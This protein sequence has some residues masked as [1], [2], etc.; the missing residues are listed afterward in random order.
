MESKKDKII[1]IV[2]KTVSYI[3]V[4]ALASVLTLVLYTPF[5]NLIPYTIYPSGTGT[6]TDEVEAT[7]NKLRQLL[8]L[9]DYCHVA[10]VDVEVLGDAAAWAMVEATGDRW[11]AYISASE[12]DA[13][14]ENQ[15]NAY[16]GIGITILSN[17]SEEGFLIQQ[18]EPNGSAKAAGIL[19]GDILVEAEGQSL[20]GKE[21]E[22]ASSL[23]RGEEGTDV[24]VAVLRDGEKITFTL[25]RMT[26]HTVVASGQLLDGNVGYVLIANFNSGCAEQAI[27]VIEDLREQ[28]AESLLFD[29]RFNPGGYKHELVNLLNYLLPAG[30]LFTSVDYTGKEIIDWSDDSCLDMPMAVLVNEYSYS[31]AEFF[32]AALEEYNWAVTAGSP[33]VGKGYYQVTL[34]LEDG[35]AVALSTGKYFTPNGVS[36]ADEGGLIPKILVEVDEETESLIY[37]QLLPLEE[38]PQVIAALKALKGE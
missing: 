28:G 9:I 24:T 33:T 19:P 6:A 21:A 35:S 37:G 34:Q 5:S 20:A 16:V 14:V 7:A 22:F 25:K 27:A 30:K 23:I 38:D 13:Y 15:N 8:N 10:D 4:A 18:V 31:A 17:S 32:A 26:I 36:L 3:L 11:S 1:K 12:M 29:V 2:L